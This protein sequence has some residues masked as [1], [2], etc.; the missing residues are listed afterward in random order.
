MYDVSANTGTSNLKMV[1][2]GPQGTSATIEIEGQGPIHL[3]DIG[4]RKLGSSQEQWGVCITFRDKVWAYRYEGKGNL[5][6]DYNPSSKALTLNSTNGKITE[7][8][9]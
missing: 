3:N 7:L 8:T 9:S 6:I 2:L 4:S 5:S 1:N